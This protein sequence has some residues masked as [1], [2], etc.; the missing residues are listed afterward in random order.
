YD[1]ETLAELAEG[2]LDDATAQQVRD[3][4]AICDPCG[5]ALADLAGVRE[6]LAAM[7]V[8]AMP[9]GVAL[10]VDKALA[11]E[12]ERRRAGGPLDPEP[13]FPEPD[14]DRIMADAPWE[15]G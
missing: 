4:L 10:R 7:P 5:E 1:L 15:T 6:V 13:S 12:A 11:A 8:P 9:L 2:L 3:H 14:W